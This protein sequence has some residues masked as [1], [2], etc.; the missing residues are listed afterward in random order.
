MSHTT[1]IVV[2]QATIAQVKEC[3]HSTPKEN[4]ILFEQVSSSL[5]GRYYPIKFLNPTIIDEIKEKHSKLLDPASE[6]YEALAV[7]RKDLRNTHGDL[8]FHPQQMDFHIE[9]IP[10]D[11]VYNKEE[12]LS[13]VQQL[14]GQVVEFRISHFNNNAMVINCPIADGYGPTHITVAY[15]PNELPFPEFK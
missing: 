14:E 13:R 7:L 4:N 5:Y 9:V 6:L 1:S 2:Q 10:R 12:L 8:I 11:S 15:F 3:T